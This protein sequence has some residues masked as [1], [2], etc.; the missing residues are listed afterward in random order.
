M[1]ET[2]EKRENTFS[3]VNTDFIEVNAEVTQNII[4]EQWKAYVESAENISER[5]Q[6]FVNWFNGFNGLIV[7]AFAGILKFVHIDGV[8][9]SVL[10]LRFLPPL[11]GIIISITTIFRIFTYRQRK[12]DKYEQIYVLE[13][14]LPF[15]VYTN[16]YKMRKKNG[17][18]LFNL[19]FRSGTLLEL[20]IPLSFL[21]IYVLMFIW[22][23]F[24]IY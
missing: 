2:Q 16:E 5:R 15:R 17:F 6:Q 7:A 21:V 13:K 4:L 18:I 11:L 8:S 10:I 1:G 22:S 19:N 9:H 20:L 23:F 12:K 3:C 14:F 24:N